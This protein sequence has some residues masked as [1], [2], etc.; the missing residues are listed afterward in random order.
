MI[1]LIAKDTLTLEIVELFED[2]IGLVLVLE[3]A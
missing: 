2:I 3:S 1:H